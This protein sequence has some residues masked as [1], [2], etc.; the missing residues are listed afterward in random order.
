LVDLGA[1]VGAALLPRAVRVEAEAEPWIAWHDGE[2]AHVEPLEPPSVGVR[3][4]VD[5]DYWPPEKEVMTLKGGGITWDDP[6]PESEV[7]GIAWHYPPQ[8][9]TVAYEDR[10]HGRCAHV[11]TCEDGVYTERC[12]RRI[13]RTAFWSLVNEGGIWSIDVWEPDA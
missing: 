12:F 3:T 11:Y 6:I 9:F 13:S 1:A 10:D 8:N 7:L 5:R 2:N 4:V